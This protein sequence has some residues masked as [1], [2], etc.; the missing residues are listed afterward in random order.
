MSFTLC[1]SGAIVIKAGAQVNSDAA[2]SGAILAQY[3]DEAEAYICGALRN[4]VIKNYSTISKSTSYAVSLLSDAASSIAATSLVS[5]E[6]TGYGG[7][8]FA[9][10]LINILYDRAGRIIP[11][12]KELIKPEDNF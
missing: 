5:Y 10:D 11:F 9:E 12:L 8:S 7:R 2:T 6:M 4:D 3:C 1:T